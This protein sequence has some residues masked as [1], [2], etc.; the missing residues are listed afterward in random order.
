[1]SDII[2]NP[3]RLVPERRQTLDERL[4][5]LVPRSLEELL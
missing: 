4:L 3:L 5:N 2:A 1:M